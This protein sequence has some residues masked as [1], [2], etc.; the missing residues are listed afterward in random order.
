MSEL[1]WVNEFIA[2]LCGKYGSS[3]YAVTKSG[4]GYKF[5]DTIKKH[6]TH[7][8]LCVQNIW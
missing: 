5:T 2:R 4:S 6:A 7:D 3:Y 1:N 8:G